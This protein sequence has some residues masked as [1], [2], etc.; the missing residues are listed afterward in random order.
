[1]TINGLHKFLSN[2]GIEFKSIDIKRLKDKSIAIDANNIMY[3]LY[4]SALKHCS[5]MFLATGD[6]SIV[7]SSWIKRVISIGLIGKRNG[8]N[9]I[10]VFDSKA[11]DLKKDTQNKRKEKVIKNKENVEKK[12]EDGTLETSDII[13]D[14]RME[15]EEVEELKEALRSNKF[16]VIMAETEAEKECVKLC[17]DRDD[18]VAVYSNDGDCLVYGCPLMI[19]KIYDDHVDVLTIGII[20]KRLDITFEQFR[21]MCIYAGTDY[22]KNIK[23]IA[24]GKLYKRL[25]EGQKL[26]KCFKKEGIDDSMVNYEE[27]KKL[28]IL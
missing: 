25:Q 1:M 24:C 23:N 20:L 16:E 9:M 4:C 27:V 26:Y 17:L 5:D 12:T 6:R 22:N 15:R 11:D 7:T 14:V 18:V 13:K 19:K 10:W 21:D 28:F 2:Q 8:I 3:P